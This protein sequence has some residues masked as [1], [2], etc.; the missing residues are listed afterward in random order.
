MIKVLLSTILSIY[1]MLGVT[2]SASANFQHGSRLY[3]NGEYA[4]AMRE[5]L[6][7]AE[8]SHAEAQH[9]IGLMYLRG[10]GVQ[11]DYQK[12]LSWFLKSG[13]QG[14]SAAQF[15]VGN[16]YNH[17]GFEQNFQK[18]AYWYRKAAAQGNIWAQHHLGNLYQFGAGVPKDYVVAYMWWNIAAGLGNQSSA[19]SRD[20]LEEDMSAEQI[21]EAQRL[22]REWM[23]KTAR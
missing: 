19:G 5:L 21:A 17:G 9:L 22:S 12:A 16:M 14:Y 11:K 10:H 18:A 6:P 3:D 23:Q 7:L 15:S 8:E 13:R 2:L 4:L 1:I 20:Q